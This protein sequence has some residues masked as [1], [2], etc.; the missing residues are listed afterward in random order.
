MA[1]SGLQPGQA[2][3]VPLVGERLV[4]QTEW[5]QA[6]ALEVGKTVRTAVE[7]LD[8]PVQYE[9]A[10]VERVAVNRVLHDNEVPQARQEGD[11][12]IVPVVHEQLVVVKR[13]VLVEELR[14]TKELQTRTQHVA[15]EVRREEISLSHPGLEAQ[16]PHGQ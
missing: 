16:Q 13:R 10:T 3:R 7:E 8:V 2:L 9:Q 4:A 11:T 6:G 12:Y 1:G 15:E 5:R 14:I